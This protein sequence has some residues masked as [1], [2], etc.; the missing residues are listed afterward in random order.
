MGMPKNI[1]LA[2]IASL[3][4]SDV[5]HAYSGKPGCSCGCIGTY[6]IL[7]ANRKEAEEDFGYAYAD[8]DINPQ[9]VSRVLHQVQWAARHNKYYKDLN[10]AP[11]IH[12]NMADDA[13]YVT[14]QVSP[15]RKYTVYLT[16]AARDR[17]MLA[18]A[19][20]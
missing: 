3:T 13:Y 11:E 17:V 18:A 19:K 10:R 1:A 8:E 7:T 15:R 14:A 9:Q 12:V 6:R 5:L 16:K 2:A 4:A 20:S